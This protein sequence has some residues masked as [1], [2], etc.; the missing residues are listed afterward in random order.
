MFGVGAAAA[1]GLSIPAP[2]DAA[3]ATSAPPAQPVD[4][5]QAVA[6][7]VESE[8]QPNQFYFV[9]RRRRFYRRRVFYYRRPRRYFIVRR[10]RYW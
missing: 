7:T 3:E 1:C 6:E 8:M 10:R 5:S 9:R 2:A 4:A